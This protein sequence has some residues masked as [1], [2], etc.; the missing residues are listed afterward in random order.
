MMTDLDT[1]LKTRK[2]RIEQTLFSL[3]P[4]PATRPEGLAEAMAYAVRSGGKRLRPI[5]CLASAEVAGGRAEDALL[6]ACAIECLHT[7]TLVHDDLPCMDNDTLRRGLPT[8]WAKY[9]E[10]TAVLVGDALQAFAFDLVART[11]NPRLVSEL[12]AAAGPAG[13]IAGQVEDIRFAGGATR[14]QVEY[15]FQHKTAD[16]F[17]CACRMGAIAAGADDCAVQAVTEFANHLGFAFQIEDDLL[18]AQQA[19]ADDAKPE[20]SCLDILTPEE[21]RAWCREETD[22]AIRALTAPALTG[23]REA[24]N[25]LAYRLVNRSV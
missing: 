16:L 5:F 18:D 21:A 13:V 8:V 24:L 7:Y 20:L 19:K 1:Y 9:G 14:E 6:P 12:A 23:S 2:E 11:G 15:I 17:R 4:L 22:A 25:S 3:L 10:A